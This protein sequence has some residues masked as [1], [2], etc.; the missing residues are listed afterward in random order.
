M[1]AAWTELD[2]HQILEDGQDLLDVPGGGENAPNLL[3]DGL[4][5]VPDQAQALGGQLQ[6]RERVLEFMHEQARAVLPGPHLLGFAEPLLVRDQDVDVSLQPGTFALVDRR[7]RF[8]V[9]PIAG[10]PRQAPEDPQIGPGDETGQQDT[11]RNGD[12]EDRQHHETIA[13]DRLLHDAL[14]HDGGIGH[15]LRAKD[16]RDGAIQHVDRH[17]GDDHD[18]DRDVGAEEQQKALL[19]RHR[20]VQ[21][22]AS[23]DQ[24]SVR[25]GT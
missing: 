6:R 21:V 22:P 7:H 23:E 17:A 1:R 15:V 4:R 10:H 5:V 3:L 18:D 24:V 13:N 9:K 12:D 25:R 14:A 8:P 11:G 2:V 20:R 16:E 19:D